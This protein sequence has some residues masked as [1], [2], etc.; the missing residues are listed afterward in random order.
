MEWKIIMSNTWFDDCIKIENHI[1][2]A[3]AEYNGL[4]K[5]DLDNRKVE[6]IGYF[7]DE[8]IVTTLFND[9]KNYNNKLIFIPCFAKHIH[10][11]DIENHEMT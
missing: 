9:V 4:F 11:Y 7:E 10:I 6:C 8:D 5:L 3:S 1:W 2:F